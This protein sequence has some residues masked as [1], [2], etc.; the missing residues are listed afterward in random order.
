[1]INLENYLDEYNTS[2]SALFV[3]VKMTPITEY[4]NIYIFNGHVSF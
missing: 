2:S 4:E 3:M 1:M